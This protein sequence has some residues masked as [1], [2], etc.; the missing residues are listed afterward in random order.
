[1][2]TLILMRH[3][4]SSWGDP[5]LDDHDRC[6]NERGIASANALGDW[7]RRAGHVAD[8]ALVSTALRTRETLEELG[9]ECE[10]T[11]DRALYLAEPDV[12]LGRLHKAAGDT[13]L[14]LGHNPGIGWLAQDLVKTPPAHPRFEDYPTGATLVVR[15]ATDDWA[16]VKTGKGEVVDFIVPRDLM[17]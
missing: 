10:A 14:M 9:L 7:L 12:M 4:K 15:F 8:T 6:L 17:E 13:V 2:K 1:M 16:S 11:Y 3:G 5:T